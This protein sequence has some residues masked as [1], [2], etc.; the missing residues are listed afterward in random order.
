[1]IT[2]YSYYVSVLQKHTEKR[3]TFQLIGE[4]LLGAGTAPWVKLLP[5]ATGSSEGGST[6]DVAVRTGACG[7][8]PAEVHGVQAHRALGGPHVEPDG[9][10]VWAAMV[11][12]LLRS[13]AV[14]CRRRAPSS[15]PFLPGAPHDP[16]ATGIVVNRSVEAYALKLLLQLNSYISD[17]NIFLILILLVHR[18]LDPS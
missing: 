13:P 7:G 10:S 18:L 12:P 8:L 16:E 1:M 4:S 6:A 9:E 3:C 11:D 2:H 17:K 14:L 15:L 5:W